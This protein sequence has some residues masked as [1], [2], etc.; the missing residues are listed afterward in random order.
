MYKTLQK[1]GFQHPQPQLVSLQDFSHQQQDFVPWLPGSHSTIGTASLRACDSALTPFLHKSLANRMSL[2]GRL[3]HGDGKSG[4][5]TF[6]VEAG[7][8]F[9]GFLGGGLKHF[10]CSPRSLGK[11]SKLT[12]IFQM[13][14]NHQVVF[15]FLCFT[16]GGVLLPMHISYIVY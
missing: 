4:K 16:H 11:W 6:F 9:K 12:N 5:G 2:F 13:G 15:L 3:K 1:M 8:W 14:W 7:G 10:L